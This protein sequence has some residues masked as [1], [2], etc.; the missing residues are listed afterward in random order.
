MLISVNGNTTVTKGWTKKI[1]SNFRFNTEV[2][3][4]ETIVKILPTGQ[5]TT[6]PN[7]KY[8]EIRADNVL[9]LQLTKGVNSV[10]IEGQNLILNNTDIDQIV[11]LNESGVDANL[12]VIFD[13]G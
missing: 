8:I 4:F 7:A 3:G 6:I 9:K 10:V 1:L 2:D 13:R 11:V 5:S 12:N